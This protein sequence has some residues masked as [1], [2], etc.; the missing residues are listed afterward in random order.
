MPSAQPNDCWDARGASPESHTPGGSSTAEQCNQQGRGDKN[1]KRIS[2][3]PADSIPAVGRRQML[4]TPAAARSHTGGRFCRC[5]L[6][7]ALAALYLASLQA[8]IQPEREVRVCAR[9]VAAQDARR[10]GTSSNA[11]PISR[12]VD[13]AMFACAQQDPA[14]WEICLLTAARK[15]SS[16]P[17]CTT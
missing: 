14:N 11:Q 2:E 15:M 8:P 7:C 5:F 13:A 16:N 6:G 4:V 9:D 12:H 3:S 17:Y 10:R 1:S